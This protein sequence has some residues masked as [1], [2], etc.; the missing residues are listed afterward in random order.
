MPYFRL[1]LRFA[2]MEM[3]VRAGLFGRK[4]KVGAACGGACFSFGIDKFCV[5]E[6]YIAALFGDAGAQG[7]LSALGIHGVQEACFHFRGYSRRLQFAHYHPTANFVEQY[8]LNTA[9]QRVQPALIIG[10]WCPER[11]NV[12]AVLVKFHFYAQGVCRGATETIIAVEVKKRVLYL[13]HNQGDDGGL[14][15]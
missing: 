5:D 14:G 10:L 9:V 6:H 3:E 13:F 12:V 11:H 1:F 4:G 2:R 8:A 15:L 7:N